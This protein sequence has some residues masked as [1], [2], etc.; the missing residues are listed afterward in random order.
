MR[1]VGIDPGKSG[2][3]C[4][5]EVNIHSPFGEGPIFCYPCPTV[6]IGKKREYD[7]VEMNKLISNPLFGEKVYIEKAQAMPKQG[8]VS[9]FSYGLGYGAWI[10]LCVA[11]GIPYQLVAPQTWKKAMLRD[12][13]KGKGASIIKAKQ[14]C[15]SIN[16]VPP[17]GRRD[18]HNLAEAYL[19]AKY[20]LLCEKD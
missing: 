3:V 1:I 11:N 20:G 14:L 5:V 9:M 18:N 19:I 17:G 10:A 7:L 12:M 4:V 2:A 13:P 16:L 8:T 15:P 6:K